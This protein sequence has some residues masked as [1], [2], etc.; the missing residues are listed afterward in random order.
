MSAPSGAIAALAAAVILVGAVVSC[1]QKAR[2]QDHDAGH[3][4]HH[5]F[6]KDWLRPDT[7][8]SCCNMRERTEGGGMI[9]DCRPT[10]F[11]LRKDGHWEAVLDDGMTWLAIPDDKII[12]E[13][14]PDPSGVDGHLCENAGVVYCAVPPTG[15]L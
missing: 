13:K 2:G 12:R 6:Y 7:G 5:D 14:N 3:A 11:R 4:R 10:A 15:A 1:G 9:G 8:T